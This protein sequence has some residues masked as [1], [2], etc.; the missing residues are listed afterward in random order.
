MTP[1]DRLWSVRVHT[2][3]LIRLLGGMEFPFAGNDK[4][5]AALVLLAE[6]IARLTGEDQE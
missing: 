5:A 4:H 3:Q 6:H 1:E 2:A